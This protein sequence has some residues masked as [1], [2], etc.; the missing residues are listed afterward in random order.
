VT[1]LAKT[2]FTDEDKRNLK[3]I[4]LELKELRK[5]VE[6]LAETLVN[7]SDKDLMKIFNS[8]QIDLK[9]NQVA[10]CKETLEKQLDA[11]EKEF[12]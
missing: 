12:R 10:N 6:E 4:A 9:E 1:W 5:L 7:L 8:D 3:G 2:V 11:A